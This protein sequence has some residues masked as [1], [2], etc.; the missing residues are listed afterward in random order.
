MKNKIL[1]FGRN[2]KIEIVTIVFYI[3][4]YIFREF[5]TDKFFKSYNLSTYFTQDRLNGIAAF[6][7]ITI[8]VYIAVVTV[9]ATT[10][11]GISK[12]IL[13]KKID[14]SLINV[15]MVGIGENFFSV[16]LS[17]FIPLNAFT[18][19]VL[20]VFLTISIISFAKFIILLVIIFKKNLQLMAQSIDEEEVYRNNMLTY[21]EEI[22]KYF[23]KHRD[24]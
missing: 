16:G 17:I 18:R 13:R 7:A 12:E 11:I 22:F 23:Q 3:V 6:F 19:Y 8:G 5:I 21:I 10:E 1:E 15:I 14:R 24:D 4:A 2:I 9:L 20:I